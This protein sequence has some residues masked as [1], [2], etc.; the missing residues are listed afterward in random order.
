MTNVLLRRRISAE[1]RDRRPGPGHSMGV[2]RFDRVA[3]HP[4][5]TDEPEPAPDRCRSPG[6]WVSHGLR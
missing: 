5:R 4:P 2:K 6:L 1:Q 3:G